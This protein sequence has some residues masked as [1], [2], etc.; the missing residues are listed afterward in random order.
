MVLHMLGKTT[1]TVAIFMLG[2]FLYGRKYKN[3]FKA[4]RL[5]LLRIVF[6]SF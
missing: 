3:M 6:L 1:A 2:V 4:F 5:S